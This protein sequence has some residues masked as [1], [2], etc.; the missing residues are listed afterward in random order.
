MSHI[1]PFL[2]AGRTQHAVCW[3][4]DQTVP[5]KA[6]MNR[7]V[8]NMNYPDAE[9]VPDDI[10]TKIPGI[11]PLATPGKYYARLAIGDEV[12]GETAFEIVKDP[13]V[14]SSQ[15]DLEAQFG[16][17]NQIIDKVSE[18]HQGIHRLR[19]MRGQ[20]QDWGK[21]SE[22]AGE[23]E[24][25][26]IRS[27]AT[28]LCEKLDAIEERLIQTKSVSE[29]DRLRMP[30]GLNAK[31]TNLIPVLL[32]A[33]VRPTQQSYAV[34]GEL[35]GRVDEQLSLLDGLVGDDI[36]AFNDLVREA[37]VEPVAVGL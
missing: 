4:P 3:S 21:H 37:N 5:A 30:A 12:V 15:E 31:L 1:A 13:R 11:G 32:S 18:T 25:G 16:L 2:M 9:M 8:W 17:W 33:D 29:R 28:A 14:Q 36:A 26:A 22:I 27:T 7:F 10:T 23:A 20:I 19:R 34:F 35:S 24:D 6:G